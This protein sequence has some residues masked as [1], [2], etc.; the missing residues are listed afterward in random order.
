MR[1]A[2]VTAILA[3]SIVGKFFYGKW[4][5]LASGYVTGI[6]VGILVKSHLLWPFIACALISILSKYVLR[7]AN[8]HLWNPSN[9]GVA[10]MLLLAPMYV[11]SLTVQAGNNGWSVAAI[12]LM[13][14]LIMYKLGRFH[15]PA[16]FTTVRE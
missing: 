11:A 16:A 4:P 1:F 10:M 7:V 8:R 12:W 5:H 15:I 3:E 14:G 6:S 2:V 9:F 13:G